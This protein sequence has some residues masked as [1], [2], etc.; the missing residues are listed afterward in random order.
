[1]EL[2]DKVKQQIN[3][4]TEFMNDDLSTAKVLAN[5]F[6]LAPVI[7]GLKNKQLP[8]NSLSA[9]TLLCLQQQ[10]KLFLEDIL[11]LQ[12]P[13]P[14]YNGKLNQVMDL[15]LQLRKQAKAKK[16]F[17]TSDTIR[18]ELL[19]MGIQIKDEKDGYMSYTLL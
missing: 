13:V 11:G 7:N 17:V 10:M 16:D 12:N 5:M 2:D 4:V 18:N 8:A 6:E 19:A 3:E 1:M 15:L 14:A 9:A